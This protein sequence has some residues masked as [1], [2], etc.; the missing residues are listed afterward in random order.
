MEATLFCGQS[1]S[2]E[3]AGGG[4]YRGVAG[5]HGA[6]AA[7]EQDKL[8][9]RRPDAAPM[10]AAERR[11]WRDYFAL[12]SGQQ[13][14]LRQFCRDE[15][16]AACVRSAAGVRLLNQPFFDTLLS[17]I[18]SQNNHIPRITGI[19]QRLREGFGEEVYP[20]VHAFP[21]P[22]R[23]A[24]LSP[25]DLAPLRAGF[26][27]RYL[28]DAA[29]QVAAG[30]VSE[31]ALAQMGDE[32]ARQALRGIC[33]VGPKVA[34]C[35]LLYALRRQNIAPMDV[36]MKRAMER[37]FPKGWPG[38]AAG[39]EGLVQLYVFCWARGEWGR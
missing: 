11:F 36:W 23:L 15:A 2:W 7:V 20:G 34:D 16:L 28:I 13:A 5:R 26:R 25:E 33:G 22:Q 12:G 10:P 27:A 8:L 39:R 31:E 35:V 37:V 4:W 6:L 29:E 3:R 18:I 21:T 1:F 9:L 32:E 38:E 19:V 30:R 24:G 14:I 17:F